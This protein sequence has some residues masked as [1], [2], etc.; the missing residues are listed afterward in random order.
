MSD[1]SF[2]VRTTGGPGEETLGS[3]LVLLADCTMGG[4][5]WMMD[6]TWIEAWTPDHSISLNT[7]SW[8]GGFLYGWSK[9]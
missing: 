8:G 7:V 1:G 2:C 6:L 4:N 9:P 3:N 5:G